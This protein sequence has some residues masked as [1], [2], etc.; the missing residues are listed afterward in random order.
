L[1]RIEHQPIRGDLQ[2]HASLGKQIKKPTDPRAEKRL[3]ITAISQL[4]GM[5]EER[6]V[7]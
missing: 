3:G 6:P 5:L 2:P 1:N 4:A 7:P